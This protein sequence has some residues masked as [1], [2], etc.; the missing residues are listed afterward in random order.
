MFLTQRELDSLFT[1]TVQDYLS[2]GY[3]ITTDH[4]GSSFADINFYIDLYDKSN[5]NEIIRIFMKSSAEDICEQIHLY[6]DVRIIIVRKYRVKHQHE[7]PL[8]PNAGEVISE[9]KFYAVCSDKYYSDNKD[10]VLN[11]H[12][13]SR[14]RE[15]ARRMSDELHEKHF[16]KV[17]D[18]PD[19]FID[20]IMAKINEIHGFGRATSS[21]I[22]S[23]YTYKVSRYNRSTGKTVERLQACVDFCFN[24]KNGFT[25]LK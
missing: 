1:N 3:I 15:D 4:A 11:I 20:N 17:S 10:D 12:K 19:H 23:I 21:C 13:K 6:T 25:I 16:F 8:W 24:S 14:T 2:K 18:L 22:D 5:K 9:H 7:Q